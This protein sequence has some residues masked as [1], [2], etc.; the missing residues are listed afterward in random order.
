MATK[1]NFSLIEEKGI[2]VVPTQYT[3]TRTARFANDDGFWESSGMTPYCKIKVLKYR[4]ELLEAA[5]ILAESNVK[6]AFGTDLGI[7]SYATNGAME[8]GEMVANGI[9]PIRALRAATSVAAELLQHDDLGVLA[10]GKA[11]DIVAV[12]G[13]PFKDITVMENVN[14]VMKAGKVYKSA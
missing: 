4:K 8:F 3:S 10:P 12:S 2:F 7:L 9:A 11:A 14:F 6:I 1:E 13:N 5:A